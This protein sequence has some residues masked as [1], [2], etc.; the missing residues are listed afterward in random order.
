MAAIVVGCHRLAVSSR[1]S[2]GEEIAA[3]GFGKSVV[4][5]EGVG[6]L[7]DGTYDIVND[8]V[9]TVGCS[10]VV[11][12]MESTIEC[13]ADELCHASIYDDELFL[14]AVLNIKYAREK[15]S[16]LS[17]NSSAELE[18]KLLALTQLQVV[19]EGGEVG[20]E[21]GNGMAVGILVVDA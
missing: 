17:D 12:L 20:V 21:I 7:A 8:A 18:V 14:G 2:D 11:D 15:C 4:L 19:G 1:R 13:R 9:C 5:D 10:E 3:T 6:G 16:H